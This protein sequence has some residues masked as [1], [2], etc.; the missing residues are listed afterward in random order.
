V[1]SLNFQFQNG[2][3]IVAHCNTHVWSATWQESRGDLLKV[4][5]F[6]KSLTCETK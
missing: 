6:G 3:P 4:D 5:S 1:S 2:I